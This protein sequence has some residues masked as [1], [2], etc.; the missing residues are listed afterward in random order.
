MLTGLRLSF[1]SLLPFLW[2]GVISATFKHD[3]NVNDSIGPFIRELKYS[4]NISAFSFMI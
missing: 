2:I 3:G 1:I 4:A